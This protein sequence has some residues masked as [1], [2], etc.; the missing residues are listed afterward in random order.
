MKSVDIVVFKNTIKDFVTASPLPDEVKRLTLNEIL[1]E[2]T[3]KTLETVRA[4]LAERNRK[5]AKKNAKGV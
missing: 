1:T 5:E 3:Q 2:Q 4:E